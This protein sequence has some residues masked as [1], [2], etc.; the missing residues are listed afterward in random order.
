MPSREAV[1]ECGMDNRKCNPQSAARIPHLE[2]T[3]SVPRGEELAKKTLNHRLGIVGGISI[4]GTTGIVKPLSEAAWTATITSSLDVAKALGREEVVLSTGRTSEKAHQQKYGLPDDCYAMMGDYTEFSLHDAG[5]HGFRMVHLCAQ[6]A[7]MIKI[8]MATPQTHVRHGV[9]EVNKA[10]EFMRKSGLEHCLP[11]AGSIPSGRCTNIFIRKRRQREGLFTAVCLAARK[12]CEEMTAEYRY[13]PISCHTREL[14]LP[15]ANKLYVIG[16]GTGPK[17]RA[18]E[19]LGSADVILAS[20]R[21]ADVFSRYDE[22][23]SIKDRIKV[24]NKVP[25]T[26]GYIKERFSQSAVQSVVLLASGDP[27][28]FG[29]GR[30]M[31]EEFG[32]ETVEILPDLSSVQEAF[33]RIQEPWDDAFF[34]SLHGGPDIAKRRKLPYEAGDIPYLLERFGKMAILTD[35][36]TILASSQRF[37]NP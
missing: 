36:E 6:W 33:A 26:V 27:L 13:L 28:F 15:K 18:R 32:K 20:G 24:I 10:M 16:L 30:R 37:Y 11:A 25:E 1:R 5:R 29:I 12:Y 23:D 21:L 22:Y 19:I 31:M 3:I 2:V 8:A 34:I 17:K 7:K 9:L 4:L 35:R 14:S